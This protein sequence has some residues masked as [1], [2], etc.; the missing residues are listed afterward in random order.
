MMR[1]FNHAKLQNKHKLH[2]WWVSVIIFGICFLGSLMDLNW[3]PSTSE[4]YQ[5]CL[6]K[7]CNRWHCSSPLLFTFGNFSPYF[8]CCLVEKLEQL[9]QAVLCWK[10]WHYLCG[11]PQ[12]LQ[13]VW[14]PCSQWKTL[15]AGTSVSE[16]MH[17]CCHSSYDLGGYGHGEFALVSLMCGYN[18]KNHVINNRYML[19]TFTCRPNI[20]LEKCACAAS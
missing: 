11:G 16:H 13:G 3:Y 15:R 1:K 2:N 5:D 18:F 4:L 19:M 9:F 17:E 20:Y 12:E 14:K 6:L 10:L 8:P 7:L